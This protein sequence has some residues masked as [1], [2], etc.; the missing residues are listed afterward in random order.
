MSEIT[1]V[2]CKA[3]QGVVCDNHIGA[4]FNAYGDLFLIHK[5]FLQSKY[6]P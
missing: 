6:K 3:P 5:I 2:L 1:H 4:V